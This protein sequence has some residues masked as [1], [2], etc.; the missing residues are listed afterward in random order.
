MFDQAVRFFSWLELAIRQTRSRVP[1]CL[2]DLAGGLWRAGPPAA[3]AVMRV[4]GHASPFRG[5]LGHR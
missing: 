1:L 3:G 5:K 4:Q 2:E